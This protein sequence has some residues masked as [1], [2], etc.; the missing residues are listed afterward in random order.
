V[1]RSLQEGSEVQGVNKGKQMGLQ[2]GT[3]VQYTGQVEK[4]PGCV[5]GKQQDGPGRG[6]IKDQ[7]NECC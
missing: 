1:R 5:E 7:G 4:G 2:D 6:V 3:G